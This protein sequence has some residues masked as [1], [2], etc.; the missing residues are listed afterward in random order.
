[1]TQSSK[2]SAL[3]RQEAQRLGFSFIGF[4]KARK[5][6]EAARRLERWLNQ[7][8]HGEMHYMENHFEKRID[9]TQLVPGAKSVISLLFNYHSDKRQHDVEAPKIST[10]AYGTDYHF[11]LK[12]KLKSLL[13]YIRDHVGHIEGRCFVDSAPILEREW[14]RLS[15]LGWVGK[16][17]MLIHP[18]A[19]SYYFLAEIIS[20]L[21]ISEDT[22]PLKDYCGTCTRCIDACPTDAI[23]PK[24]Y[25]LDGSKCISYLTIELRDAIP[26]EFKSK[27]DNWMFGCDICQ[28]VCPW[29]RFSTPTEEST[30]QPSQELLEMS[31]HDWIELTEETF[32]R[33]FRKSPVKRTKFTGLTRN[34]RFLTE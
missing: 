26:E 16:N 12:D 18:K 25:V 30:F 14:A 22:T 20:D 7:G 23:S 33:V 32:R 11:V 17:T 27:M 19:G 29:N 9:P 5:L 24:G 2:Y 21:D 31:E 3:I 34:I 1:M 6:D 10:Y 8:N 13:K 15:G 4:S 28:E